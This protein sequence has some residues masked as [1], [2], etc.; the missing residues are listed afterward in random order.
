MADQTPA[1]PALLEASELGTKEYWDALYTRESTNHAA[2]PTDEGTIWF[3]DSSAE[4]K[5]VTLLRSSSLTGFDPAT[6]SFLDL[7]TGNGHLLFRLRDEGVRGEDSDEEE[8]E[9]EGEGEG[10]KLFKGR[11]MGTDYSATSISF[12]RAVAA[13]RGLVDSAVEFVEWDILASP[14]DAVLSG[15]NADGWDVV[16]DKGTFDAVS[17]MGDPE[18]GKR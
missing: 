1:T 2:D 11:I 3:D 17:L 9:G 13:E 14:S 12:A 15:P 10:G 16:L 6:A 7:G 5:L 8:E 4:D 18:A